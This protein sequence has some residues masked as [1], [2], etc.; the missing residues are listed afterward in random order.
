[1]K[2]VQEPKEGPCDQQCDTLGSREAHRLGNQLSDHHVQG[3]EEGERA[4]QCE[5]MGE[6]LGMRSRSARP[7]GLKDLRQRGFAECAD[8]QACERNADAFSSP[9]R[10]MQVL[11]DRVAEPESLFFCPG[12]LLE[13]EFDTSH[14]VGF[15]M[16]GSWPVFFNA[17]QAYRKHKCISTPNGIVTALSR[18]AGKRCVLCAQ[19]L[20]GFPV[21]GFR[22]WKS[23]TKDLVERLTGGF[24]D[25]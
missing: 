18:H 6:E 14:P 24:S 5:G 3:A 19:E 17:D 2:G 11:R 21:S 22:F 7:D 16:P 20:G 12:S 13:N 8:G 9:A 4:S 10:L 15:G 25:F 1:M 23:R